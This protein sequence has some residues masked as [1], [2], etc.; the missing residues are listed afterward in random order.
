[1][2]KRASI[3]FLLAAAFMLLATSVMPHHH[4]HD[5][6]CIEVGDVGTGTATDSAGN[7]NESSCPLSVRT[8]FVEKNVQTRSCPVLV[9]I[10]VSALPACQDR[11]EGIGQRKYVRFK[12]RILFDLLTRDNP[13]RAPP[14]A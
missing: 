1:M 9:A 12:E 7:A 3:L 6:L 11:D 4:H 14:A 5:I 13:L 2:K 10:P 8:A